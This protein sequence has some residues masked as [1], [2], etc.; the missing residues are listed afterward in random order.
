[1]YCSQLNRIREFGWYRQLMEPP[2][3]PPWQNPIAG[4]QT[5][6]GIQHVPIHQRTANLLH[7]LTERSQ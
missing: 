6:P 5:L 7:L 4:E 3:A 2:A 1:M